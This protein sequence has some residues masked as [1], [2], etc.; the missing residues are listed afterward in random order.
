LL[1]D[2]HLLALH[3][4]DASVPVIASS[5]ALWVDT[6]RGHGRAHLTQELIPRACRN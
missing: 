6:K 1:C 2:K 4:L 3:F 5:W